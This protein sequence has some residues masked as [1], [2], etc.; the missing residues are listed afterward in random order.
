MSAFTT[1]YAGQYNRV[2]DA[3]RAADIVTAQAEAAGV[4][5]VA[6]SAAQAEAARAAT[7][8]RNDARRQ[9]VLAVAS[10]VGETAVGQIS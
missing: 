10:G 4:S 1:G 8:E 2:S 5:V 6:Y 9:R 3:P 7:A